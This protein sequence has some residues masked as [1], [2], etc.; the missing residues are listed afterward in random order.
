MIIRNAIP[1]KKINNPLIAYFPYTTASAFR[2]VRGVAVVAV[3]VVAAVV[4]VVG[5][6]CVCWSF[7]LGTVVNP[8]HCVVFAG[9]Y[10]FP[11]KKFLI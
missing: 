10:G 1:T 2:P 4:V 5:V 11:N 7:I 8:G 9:V 3:V 6:C